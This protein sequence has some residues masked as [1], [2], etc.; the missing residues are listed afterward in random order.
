M[1]DELAKEEIDEMREKM[2]EIEDVLI[3][4]TEKGLIGWRSVHDAEIFAFHGKVDYDVSSPFGCGVVTE[5]HDLIVQWSDKDKCCL[6]CID[7]HWFADRV[8]NVFL[9]LYKA[10]DKRMR[11]NNYE[12]LTEYHQHICGEPPEI[13]TE[14]LFKQGEQE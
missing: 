8:T 7:G 13:N 1:N 2:I 4:A 9:R 10:I 6:L 11:R 3:S 5:S 14:T 12:W